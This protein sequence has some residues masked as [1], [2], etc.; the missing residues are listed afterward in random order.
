MV[1]GCECFELL[2]FK[3]RK[4]GGMLFDLINIVG[5]EGTTNF[6]QLLLH[7]R[8]YFVDFKLSV[9]FMPHKATELQNDLFFGFM[10]MRQSERYRIL[11]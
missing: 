11:R 6:L 9:F 4:F 3:A 8:P 5:G 1:L 2:V 10:L 7:Y